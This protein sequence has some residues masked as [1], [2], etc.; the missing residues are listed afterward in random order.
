MQEQKPYKKVYCVFN[1]SRRHYVTSIE[2][3]KNM[4][5]QAIAEPPELV[6]L[7]DVAESITS[8][9][10]WTLSHVYFEP[11]LTCDKTRASVDI[12]FSVGEM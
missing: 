11:A 1:Y 9:Q 12:A 6:M 3:S 8:P 2:F 10:L 5:S 7:D 4:A